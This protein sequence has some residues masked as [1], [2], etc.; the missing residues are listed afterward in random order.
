MEYYKPSFRSEILISLPM[1]IHS[2]A[3][4]QGNFCSYHMHDYNNKLSRTTVEW[5]KVGH[6]GK[7]ISALTNAL[8]TF[9][10]L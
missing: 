3:I 7:I 9:F 10:L 6:T 1:D 2:A 4:I 5:K 8:S